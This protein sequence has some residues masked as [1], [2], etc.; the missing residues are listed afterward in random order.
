MPLGGEKTG[1]Q[2]ALIILYLVS[3][4]IRNESSGHEPVNLGQAL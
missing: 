2:N 3:S 1:L 4:V